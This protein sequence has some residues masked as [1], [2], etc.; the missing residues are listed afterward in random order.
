MEDCDNPTLLILKH[1]SGHHIGQFHPP[2][3]LSVHSSKFRLY[4]FLWYPSSS[5]KWLLSNMFLHALES[6][7][8]ATYSVCHNLLNFTI[9][10]AL[11]DLYKPHILSLPDILN[12]WFTSS[13]LYTN[14]FLTTL[15][16]TSCSLS[17]F[18]KIWD[19][20]LHPYQTTVYISVL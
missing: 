8:V 15:L 13:L 20:I 10:T 18:F 9:I 19:Q 3:I 7:V 17:S 1:A 6:P 11:G 16:S 14:I 2:P 12:H 4:V 5:S